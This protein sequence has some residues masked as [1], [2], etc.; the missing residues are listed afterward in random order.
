ME[1]PPGFTSQ[2]Y[3]TKQKQ[4]SKTIRNDP[5]VLTPSTPNFKQAEAKYQEAS[6]A[7]GEFRTIYLTRYIDLL[8][9]GDRVTQDDFKKAGAPD[10]LYNTFMTLRENE[11]NALKE[12]AN[13]KKEEEK[14]YSTGTMGPTPKSQSAI[15]KNIIGG[16]GRKARKY[17]Q[18]K[19][20]NG[21]SK[22][23]RHKT[24]RVF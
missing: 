23:R 1:S 4:A 9:K 15:F 2:N 10:S 6:R 5:L 14:S 24:R 22:I 11:S 3:Y 21:P 12:L 13:L 19:K 20:K 8:L 17:T 18:S 16:R 7:L